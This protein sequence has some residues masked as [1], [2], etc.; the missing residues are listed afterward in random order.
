MSKIKKSSKQFPPMKR[1]QIFLPQHIID[2]VH[3]TALRS[4]NS[5]GS[6]IRGV[7]TNYM[8]EMA[9]TDGWKNI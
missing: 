5:F 7:L 8:E 9:K 4:G 3:R 6:V 1:K 2:F